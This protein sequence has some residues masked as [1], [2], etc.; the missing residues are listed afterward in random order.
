[1]IEKREQLGGPLFRS[2]SWTEKEIED[3]VEK[4]AEYFR[5]TGPNWRESERIYGGRRIKDV[6][7]TAIEC[8]LADPVLL[9][10]NK[11]PT[12]AHEKDPSTNVPDSSG[13]ISEQNL[14]PNPRNLQGHLQKPIQPNGSQRRLF[15]TGTVY[16]KSLRPAMNPD[17]RV[18]SPKMIHNTFVQRTKTKK[19][20][21]PIRQRLQQWQLLYDEKLQKQSS[22]GQH[23]VPLPGSSQDALLQMYDCDI[24]V[25]S[26]KQDGIQGQDYLS[27]AGIPDLDPDEGQE[28]D[29]DAILSMLYLSPGDLV[30]IMYRFNKPNRYIA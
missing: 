16:G 21:Q 29:Q 1:L 20:L 7:L 24:I 9:A 14:Q 3:A 8:A 19:V 26:N 28:A 18:Q 25:D 5:E 27:T 12:Q 11:E 10:H 15:S 30:E 6:L 22:D 4:A 23:E 17:M 2:H 13:N